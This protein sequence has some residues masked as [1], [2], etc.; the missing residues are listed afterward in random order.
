MII[1]GTSAAV[2]AATTN[3]SS[4]TTAGNEQVPDDIRRLYEKIDRDDEELEELK[5]VSFEVIQNKIE[6]LR[7]RFVDQCEKMILRVMF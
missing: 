1:P 6:Q 2:A 5:I 7:K 3:E 4:T